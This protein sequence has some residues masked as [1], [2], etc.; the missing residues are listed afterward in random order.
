[1]ESSIL[2]HSTSLSGNL[3]ILASLTFFT[4]TRPFHNILKYDAV[5]KEKAVVI[6]HQGVRTLPAETDCSPI[7]HFIEYLLS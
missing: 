2:I 7:S 5:M 6:H 3:P 1:M 4:A